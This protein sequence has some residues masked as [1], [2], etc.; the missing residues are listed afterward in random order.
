MNENAC[1]EIIGLL[2]KYLFK[3]CN[4]LAVLNL[5][6]IHSIINLLVKLNIP[7]E[8]TYIEGTRAYAKSFTLQITISPTLTI[9]K[10]FQLEEGTLYT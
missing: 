7:F 4:E 9:T 1:N 3:N 6:Q 5:S 2:S 10:G 8:L